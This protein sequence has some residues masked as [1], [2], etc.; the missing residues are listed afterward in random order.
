M[1]NPLPS[2]FGSRLVLPMILTVGLV[3]VKQDKSCNI[4]F[5][6]VFTIF[7]QY[8]IIWMYTV[9]NLYVA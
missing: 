9:S 7:K 6:L 3:H 2:P 4:L 5:L 1:I 8:V